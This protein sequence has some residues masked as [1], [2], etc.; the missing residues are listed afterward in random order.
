V[1][2]VQHVQPD[3]RVNYIVIPAGSNLLPGGPIILF[4]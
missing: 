4:L 1:T 3:Q 2:A